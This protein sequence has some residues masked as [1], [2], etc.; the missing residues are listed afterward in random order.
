M[1]Q[2]PMRACSK[3]LPRPVILNSGGHPY[4]GP[5]DKQFTA[6]TRITLSHTT[7]KLTR[8]THSVIPPIA[9]TS[10]VIQVTETA[11]VMAKGK[12]AVTRHCEASVSRNM[13]SK[14]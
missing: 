4:D 7:S 2:V 3:E 9:T 8:T 14:E 5:V 13:F 11:L 6:P 1:R 10:K 12:K